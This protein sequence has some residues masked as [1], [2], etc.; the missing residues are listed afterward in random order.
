MALCDN[1]T[2]EMLISSKKIKV[3]FKMFLVGSVYFKQLLLNLILTTLKIVSQKM[4]RIMIH[5]V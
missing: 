3:F 2:S 4:P 1:L 5:D